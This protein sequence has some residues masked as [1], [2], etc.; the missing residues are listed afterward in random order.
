M[1]ESPL[2]KIQSVVQKTAQTIADVIGLEVEVADYNLICVA[3]TGKSNKQYGKIMNAGFVYKHVMETQELIFIEHP[4]FHALCKP[5]LHYH[6]CPEQLEL[7]A[8][9]VHGGKSMGV[10]GLVSFS[11]E[12]SQHFYKNKE[13]MMQF[14]MKMT[15][16][17]VGNLEGGAFES[18][19][20][21]AST[22]FNLAELEKD[23]IQRA[24]LEVQNEA[25]KT[26]RTDKAASLLGISRAT[27][28][29]KIREYNL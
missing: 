25:R 14:L 18:R 10:I 24:L 16:L 2:I 1:K 3:G 9:L 29:R 15:E 21:K 7:A 6:N 13:W 19:S 12:Q 17:I 22:T 11:Q 8:P 4:G 5:C 20:K 23:T 27:L 28:Y 26:D